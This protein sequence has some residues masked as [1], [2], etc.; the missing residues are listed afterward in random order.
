[1]DRFSE[2]PIAIMFLV[3][4]GIRD[5][6]VCLRHF[7]CGCKF[8]RAKGRS[9]RLSILLFCSV[10]AFAQSISPASQQKTNP[11]ASAADQKSQVQD[12]AGTGAHSP[13][14]NNVE[15]LSDTLGVDFG[16]YLQS[17]LTD[18]RKNWYNAIPAS[19]RHKQGKVVIEFTIAKDGRVRGVKPIPASGEIIKLN[20]FGSGDADLERAACAGI[21]A[22]DPFPPLPSAF[23][24]QYLSLRVS[25]LYNPDKSDLAASSSKSSIGVSL[26]PIG[27]NLQVPVGG[28]TVI[29]ATV[30]GTQ[31]KDV[32]WRVSGSGCSDSSCGKMADDLYLAPSVLPSPPVVTLTAISKADP[33]ARASITVHIVQ[34]TPAH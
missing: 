7:D 20:A 23:G 25:F 29:T 13:Q 19:A 11:P 26:W 5:V 17:V 14:P 9:M 27:D 6:L 12:L 15:I 34:P 21:T 3:A 1:M 10:I 30:T 24:G 33:T 22:S 32:E 18:V 16:S 31:E 8:G 4:S 28:S 2:K